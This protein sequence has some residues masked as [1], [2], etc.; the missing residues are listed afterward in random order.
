MGSDYN[1]LSARQQVTWNWMPLPW[2]GCW[3]CPHPRGTERWDRPVEGNELICFL[4]WRVLSVYNCTFSVFVLESAI[5]LN[6]VRTLSE[7]FPALEWGNWISTF[8]RTLRILLQK[9]KA[10]WSQGKNWFGL[11]LRSSWKWRAF[12]LRI[13]A[14]LLH[15]RVSTGNKPWDP[16]DPRKQCSLWNFTLWNA[17][18]AC[19]F[20]NL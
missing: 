8:E 20:R 7:G 14:L 2:R 6:T 5:S 9:T 11:E 1:F 15:T 3:K 17:L 18:W 13:S 12:P 16:R 19:R 4:S 10:P